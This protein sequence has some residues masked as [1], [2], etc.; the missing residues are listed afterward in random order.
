MKSLWVNKGLEF[1]CIVF[2]PIHWQHIDAIYETVL[3][4]IL[5]NTHEYIAFSSNEN[6]FQFYQKRRKY[7]F[8]LLVTPIVPPLNEFDIH[9]HKLL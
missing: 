7:Y 1:F 5:S 2:G 8:I 4:E 9:L 6:N 3:L